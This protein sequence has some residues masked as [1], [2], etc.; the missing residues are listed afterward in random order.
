MQ[1]RDTGFDIAEVLDGPSGAADLSA[2]AYDAPWDRPQQEEEEAPPQTD[3]GSAW[4]EEAFGFGDELSFDDDD[5]FLDDDDLYAALDQALDEIEQEQ[6]VEAVKA[7]A[8]PEHDA[9]EI[10]PAP[11]TLYRDQLKGMLGRHTRVRAPRYTEMQVRTTAQDPRLNALIDDGFRRARLSR[12]QRR[13]VGKIKN[14]ELRSGL[15]Y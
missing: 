15:V 12:E 14:P 4:G 7:L 13:A 9:L 11:D 10:A 5:D 8:T 3:E 2:F 1:Q 6:R